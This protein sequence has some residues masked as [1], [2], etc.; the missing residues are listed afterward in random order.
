L[1]TMKKYVIFLLIVII[2]QQFTGCNAQVTETSTNAETRIINDMAGR[3]VE[4]P[5]EV[6]RV[7]ATGPIGTIML[8]TLVPEKLA[9]WNSALSDTEKKYLSPQYQDLPI[10][11]SWKGTKL[12][13]NIE[14][15]LK[16]DPN[17][18]INMGDVSEKYISD[19]EAIQEQLHIPVVMV[20]GQLEKAAEV[21]EFLGNILGSEERACKLAYYASET[22]NEVTSAV[23]S[24]PEHRRIS[25]YYAEGVKGLETEIGNTINTEALRIA[26]AV[27]VAND[28]SSQNT[29]RIQVSLEQILNWNPD[30]ILISTD[31][32]K[33]HQLYNEITSGIWEK[34]DAV[35]NGTVY[36]IP[37]APY[38]WL[39]RP[40]S[41]NRLIGVKWLANLLYPEVYTIDI[42]KEIREFFQLFYSYNIG[43]EEI[44]QMLEY[45]IQK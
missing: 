15:I 6:K 21:Y 23:G 37:F 19:T 26:G 31:G 33:N 40:P 22:L 13:G 5:S 39:N 45:S 36:E 17:L 42:E 16:S 11:G 27:N 9:G 7:C 41:V 2:A 29:R 18:L 8:Y 14:D 43:D 28:I 24:I 32:D 44:N 38:D 4:I 12:N 1:K 35:Q 34:I 25:F 3:T 20:D 30:V 10:L